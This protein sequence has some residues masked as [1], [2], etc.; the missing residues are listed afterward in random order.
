MSDNKYVKDLERVADCAVALMDRQDFFDLSN[1]NIHGE[2][3]IALPG[4]MDDLRDAVFEICALYKDRF[5]R[6]R[7]KQKEIK[8]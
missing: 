1:V 6:D 5:K 4:E 8:K 7:I 3:A 2:K